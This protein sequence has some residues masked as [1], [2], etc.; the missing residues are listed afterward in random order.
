MVCWYDGQI[1]GQ[2]SLNRN[3]LTGS[4]C[5]THQSIQVISGYLHQER[6]EKHMESLVGFEPWTILYKAMQ[7]DKLMSWLLA[8]LIK[9][10]RVVSYNAL[11]TVLHVQLNPGNS[12][13]QGKLKLLRVI[14][15]SSKGVLNKT[16]RNT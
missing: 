16:T 1:C 15:V 3:L 2:T 13:C 9:L 4:K 8:T 5:R 11:I 12:N 7:A 6:E 14:G 10:E